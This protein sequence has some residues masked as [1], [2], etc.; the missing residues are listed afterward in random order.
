MPS[1]YS[2]RFLS[3]DPAAFTYVIFLYCN[4]RTFADLAVPDAA[5]AVLFSTVR[6]YAI[7]V[8][9]GTSAEWTGLGWYIHWLIAR[10]S[11]LVTEI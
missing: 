6:V 10:R 5:A 2:C 1:I 4:L 9:H 3:T 11:W 7:T 8:E